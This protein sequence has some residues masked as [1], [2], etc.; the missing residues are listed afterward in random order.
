MQQHKIISVGVSRSFHAYLSCM[1][2]ALLPSPLLPT[3]GVSYPTALTHGSLCFPSFSTA[4][5]IISR[6]ANTENSPPPL[7]HVSH[8]PI[9]LHPKSI[10]TCHCNSPEISFPRKPQTIKPL[11]HPQHMLTISPLHKTGRVRNVT[12]PYRKQALCLSSP[13]GSVYRPVSYPFRVFVNQS[14]PPDIKALC[15]PSEIA[16]KSAIR[17]SIGY[18]TRLYGKSI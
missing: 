15:L 18:R 12:N 1:N 6:P 17:C 13:G 3:H 2:T 14:F 7:P 16:P 9:K 5:L 10:H 11:I 8:T 4:H